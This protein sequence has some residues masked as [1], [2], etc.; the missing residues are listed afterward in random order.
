MNIKYISDTAFVVVLNLKWDNK[1]EICKIDYF[2]KAFQRK[3][4][5]QTDDDFIKP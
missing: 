4:Y 5:Q 1:C 2:D 3:Y